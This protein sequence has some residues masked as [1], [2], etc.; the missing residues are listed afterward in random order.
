MA[1]A[2]VVFPNPGEP[3]ILN[4]RVDCDIIDVITAS[5]SSFRPTKFESNCGTQESGGVSKVAV[6]ENTKTLCWIII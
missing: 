3:Q 1:M 5:H 6:K 4:K 2:V